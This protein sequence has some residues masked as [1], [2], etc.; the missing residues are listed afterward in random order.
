MCRGNK[1]DREQ[2]SGIY[3]PESLPAERLPAVTE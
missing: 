1:N 3:Q 2:A